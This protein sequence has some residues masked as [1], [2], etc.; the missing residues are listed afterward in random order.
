MF[1]LLKIIGLSSILCALV[2]VYL[3]LFQKNII[4]TQK[5]SQLEKERYLLK[6]EISC[7]QTALSNSLLWVNIEKRASDLK[8][9]L[10]YDTVPGMV[11]PVPS[12]ST[13]NEPTQYA[14]AKF[15]ADT[16]QIK[17]NN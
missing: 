13:R 14:H 16:T 1:K 3:Y 12:N 17:L 2:L 11:S 15:N 5:L 6:E 4:Y 10:V 7:L 9:K 8:L